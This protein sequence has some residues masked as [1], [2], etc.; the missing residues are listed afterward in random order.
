MYKPLAPPTRIIVYFSL[1]KAIDI[2]L[3]E[4]V[5]PREMLDHDLE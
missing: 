2:L 1:L 4:L 5:V 3:N